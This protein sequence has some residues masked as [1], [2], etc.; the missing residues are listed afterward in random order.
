[1]GLKQCLASLNVLAQSNDPN[2]I[3][4]MESYAHT[5]LANVGGSKAD[6]LGELI[7]AFR[8]QAPETEM[9]RNIVLGLAHLGRS[10]DLPHLKA[11]YTVISTPNHL[12]SV[13]ESPVYADSDS[14]AIALLKQS[15]R[16][17]RRTDKPS[18]IIMMRGPNSD[19]VVFT[20]AIGDLRR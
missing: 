16:D 14:E 8:D 5:Y 19:R 7:V 6:A 1:M 2:G 20:C 10:V 9:S 4:L 3:T 17:L 12:G 15:F 11:L 18:D 13:S